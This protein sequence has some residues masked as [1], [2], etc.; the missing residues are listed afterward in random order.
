MCYTCKECYN[1]AQR[2][3]IS[4]PDQRREISNAYII[5]IHI[6]ICSNCWNKTVGCEELLIYSRDFSENCF[7]NKLFVSTCFNSIKD[8][9]TDIKD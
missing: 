6:C 2:H 8:C 4:S 7:I 3:A 5:A 1:H 9:L